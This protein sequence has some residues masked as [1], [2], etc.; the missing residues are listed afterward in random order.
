[1]QN[2][3]ADLMTTAENDEICG[4][5][6]W[7]VPLAYRPDTAACFAVDGYEFN[8]GGK[9]VRYLENIVKNWLHEV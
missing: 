7:N 1:M 4:S 3:L 5:V 9:C 6:Q 8:L 2:P